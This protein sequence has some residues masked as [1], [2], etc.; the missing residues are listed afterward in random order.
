MFTCCTSKEQWSRQSYGTTAKY[1]VQKDAI[2]CD[3]MQ[4][5]A[6]QRNDTQ[7]DAILGKPVGK[8]NSVCTPVHSKIGTL[9]AEAQRYHA[10][11]HF[12]CGA[13]QTQQSTARTKC[14]DCIGQRMRHQYCQDLLV[15]DVANVVC[16]SCQSPACAILRLAL[17]QSCSAITWLS[18]YPMLLAPHL[19]LTPS[20]AASHLQAC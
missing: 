7:N 8:L 5:D 11:A 15:S 6:R 9:P 20:P 17:S 2:Q 1:S 16:T 10:L 3:I 13:M 4:R 19:L 12:T 18:A 14:Q